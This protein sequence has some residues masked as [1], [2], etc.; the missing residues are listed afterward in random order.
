[1]PSAVDTQAQLLAEWRDIGARTERLDAE[2]PRRQAEIATARE[3]VTKP[4]TTSTGHR[5]AAADLCGRPRQNER[6]T[7]SARLLRLLP[8]A[9][10]SALGVGEI[11]VEGLPTAASG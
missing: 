11:D 6:A 10:G 8:G 2:I 5:S 7:R 9:P 1:M 4:Q 3:G